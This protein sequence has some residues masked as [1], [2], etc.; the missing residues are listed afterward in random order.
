MIKVPIDVGV[1][2]FYTRNNSP[3]GDV[4]QELR[5]L[6]KK[7]RIVFIP[8]NDKKRASP[9]LAVSAKILENTPDHE[10]RVES[11]R[12]QDP[13]QKRRGG[14]LAVSPGNNE[15]FFFANKKLFQGLG[16]REIRQPHFK[17]ADDLGVVP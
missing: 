12:L 7:G 4:V 16:E 5:T 13:C 14:G 1:V 3:R 2:E 10:T 11:C 9:C 15:Q 8:F 17:H 6:V